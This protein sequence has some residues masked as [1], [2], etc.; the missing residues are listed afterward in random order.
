[1]VLAP[2]RPSRRPPADWPPPCLE[3]AE[4][5]ADPDLAAA[6]PHRDPETPRTVA[7]PGPAEPEA[8]EPEAAEP[9][10]IETWYARPRRRRRRRRAAVTVAMALAVAA[11]SAAVASGRFAV[12]GEL[13]GGPTGW[14]GAALGSGGSGFPPDLR[15]LIA[16]ARARQ[17]RRR[18][19]IAM[20]AAPVAAAAGGWGA[21]GGPHSRWWPRAP[22]HPPRPRPAVR[23]FRVI[24]DSPRGIFSRPIALAV[25]SSAVWV[26]NQSAGGP[27]LFGT[28]RHPI[29]QL[30]AR[31]GRWLR[32]TRRPEAGGTLGNATAVV[33]RRHA[34]QIE[35]AGRERGL[36]LDPVTR[37]AG[38]FVR[39]GP[40][41]CAQCGALEKSHLWIVVAAPGGVAGGLDE[42]SASSGQLVRALPWPQNLDGAVISDVTAA[43]SSVWLTGSSR[44]GSPLVAAISTASGQARVFA[45]PPASRSAISYPGQVLVH[46]GDVWVL[47]TGPAPT[48][49]TPAHFRAGL[50][51]LSAATGRILRSLPGRRVGLS[52][53]V[54]FAASGPDLWVASA[55]GGFGDH[56]T[57]TEISTRTGRLVRIFSGRKYRFR[58][59]AAIAAAGPRIWVMNAHSVTELLARQS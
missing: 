15:M 5:P 10:D 50:I 1:M 26:F 48:V 6:A 51:E 4:F 40:V 21:A 42:L 34:W 47:G 19:R 8:A 23:D 18:R 54:G 3:P 2:P 12:P 33:Y 36:Y 11:A 27:G 55:D 52:N 7:T 14:H 59:P 57:V 38:S 39:G 29:T 56:G 53:A 9:D 58:S 25:T 24:G 28:G 31:T 49:Q 41:A 45:L 30:N 17:H 13:T 43:G 32:T 20:A 37:P 22:H 46:G 44:T 16:E 35:T